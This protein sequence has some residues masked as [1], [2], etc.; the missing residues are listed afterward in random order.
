MSSDSARSTALTIQDVLAEASRMPQDWHGAGSLS[1][2]VLAAIA[3]H[4]ASRPIRRSVETG[5]GKSTLLLSHLSQDHTVFT[6][7]GADDSLDVVRDSTLLDRSTVEFVVGPTQQTLPRF[8]FTHPL[9]FALIDGPHGYPFPDLEYYYIY[10][11]LASDALLVI[12]DIHIPTIF[13]LYAFLKEDEMFDLLEVVGTTAFFRR[14]S[15]S[16]FDPLADGWWTQRYNLDRFP[17]SQFPA[18]GGLRPRLRSFVP[19]PVRKGIRR[20]VPKSIRSRLGRWMM[21]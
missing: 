1:G 7:A 9:D 10:P 19:V 4:A 6:I 2:E 15:A 20:V 17:L 5:T 14:T 21:S 16:V 8:A 13:K 18:W 11:H 3:R 12:D